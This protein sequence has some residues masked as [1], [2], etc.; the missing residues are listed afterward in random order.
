MSAIRK[1][2]CRAVLLLCVILI[3]L[4]FSHGFAQAPAPP[5]PAE[6][7]GK[8]VKTPEAL[9]KTEEVQEQEKIRKFEQTQYELDEMGMT[10]EE[11]KM[12]RVRRGNP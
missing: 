11:R 4:P 10:P 6:D 12:H 8:E 7:E 1:R 9:E 2:C 3:A 5:P